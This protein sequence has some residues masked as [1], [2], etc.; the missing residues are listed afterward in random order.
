MLNTTGQVI[1][2]VRTRAGLTQQEFADVLGVHQTTISSYEA[3]K[4][5]P[6]PRREGRAI[7]AFAR[8]CG[9][10]VSRAR[11]SLDDLYPPA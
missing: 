7:V 8:R 11:L 3:D 1:R 2:V 5:L 9:I 10:R 6:D 4:R